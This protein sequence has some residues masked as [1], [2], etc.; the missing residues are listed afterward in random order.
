MAAVD[1]WLYSVNWVN[2]VANR[3]TWTSK[4]ISLFMWMMSYLTLRCYHQSCISNFPLLYLPLRLSFCS[5]VETQ[6][7]GAT[8]WRLLGSSYE[9]TCT[10]KS[11]HLGVLVYYLTWQH[12]SS[13]ILFRSM[14]WGIII[15]GLLFLD[16]HA[17]P[18]NMSWDEGAR[19]MQS[20]SVWWMASV[21]GR[22]PEMATG[23]STSCPRH[24]MWRCSDHESARC[25]ATECFR[26]EQECRFVLLQT[27]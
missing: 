5:T 25:S 6:D 27:A 21:E 16:Q 20:E 9:I 11:F 22:L 1:S 26:L 17:V 15:S 7:R 19:I 8:S 24:T 10:P 3:N 2:I 14:C 13:R 12:L 23:N 18:C 4:Y